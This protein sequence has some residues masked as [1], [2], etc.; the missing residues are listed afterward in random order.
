MR[1]GGA[2]RASVSCGAAPASS[3]GWSVGGSS[4]SSASYLKRTMPRL[5]SSEAST[6]S[7]ISSSEGRVLRILVLHEEGRRRC[8]RFD[9]HFPMMSLSVLK[10]RVTTGRGVLLYSAGCMVSTLLYRMLYCSVLCLMPS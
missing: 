4:T 2:A 8:I 3:P 7:D 10:R 9:A 5:T 1:C 6:L